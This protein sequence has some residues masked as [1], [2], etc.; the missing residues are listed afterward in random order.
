MAGYAAHLNANTPSES[1]G[2][3]V[4]EVAIFKLQP[5]GFSIDDATSF[6]WMLDWDKIQDH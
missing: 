5:R 6:A 4:T 2:K 1:K 3:P